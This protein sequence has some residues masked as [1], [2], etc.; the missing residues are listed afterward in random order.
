MKR[1]DRRRCSFPSFAWVR[2]LSAARLWCRT[3]GSSQLD[4]DL[5]SR[6]EFAEGVA[7]CQSIPGATAMQTAAFVGLRLAGG[8][9]AVVAYVGFGLPAVLLMALASAAYGRAVD[10]VLLQA[11]FRGFRATTVALTANAASSFA[12][13]HVRSVPDALVAVLAALALYAS[14]SPW[15]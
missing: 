14:A 13:T 4:A 15:R 12:R 3:S 2:R 8:P 11:A 5:L 6:E 9:G 10:V 7:L 1:P